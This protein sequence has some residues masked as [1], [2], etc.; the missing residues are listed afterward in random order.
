MCAVVLINFSSCLPFS[1][2]VGDA[3]SGR[4]VLGGSVLYWQGSV[5]FTGSLGERP[6]WCGDGFLKLGYPHTGS[7]ENFIVSSLDTPSFPQSPPGLRVTG[8]GGRA[9]PAGG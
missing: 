7:W 2:S 5:L 3:S 4:H 9:P 1:T 6:G 8:G